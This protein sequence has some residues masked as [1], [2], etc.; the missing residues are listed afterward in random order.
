MKPL[1]REFRFH[2]ERANFGREVNIYCA[3]T[4]P[5][6]S[7]EV[8][9]PVVIEKVQ[10]ASVVAEAFL[11]LRPEVAQQLMDELWAAGFRPVDGHGSTGQLAAVERHLEDM[12]Q[13][14]TTMSGSPLPSTT[15]KEVR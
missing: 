3:R 15:R 8:L 1:S 11:K 5:D 12:R 2:V 9:R 13:L 7:L 14:V 10:E 6:E 4:L